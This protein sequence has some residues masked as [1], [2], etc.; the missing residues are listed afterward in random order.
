MLNILKSRLQFT[1]ESSHLK[2]TEI[3]LLNIT[4]GNFFDI[5][6]TAGNMRCV[7]SETHCIFE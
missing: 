2:Q 7:R 4:N 3:I 6:L 1:G 5:Y